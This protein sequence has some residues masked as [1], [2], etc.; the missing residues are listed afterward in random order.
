M[1]F[2]IFKGTNN[3]FYFRIKAANGQ[4][5]AISE[6][7]VQKQSAKDTIENIK[8]NAATAPVIDLA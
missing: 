6:G 5:I 3:Q 7:Y 8:K 1:K 2:E 4:T